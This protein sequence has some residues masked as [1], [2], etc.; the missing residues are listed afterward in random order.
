VLVERGSA[1]RVSIAVSWLHPV[2]PS[3][4]LDG[5]VLRRCWVERATAVRLVEFNDLLADGF[6]TGAESLDDYL[7]VF[8]ASS[9]LGVVATFDECVV[10]GVPARDDDCLVVSGLGRVR[11]VCIIGEES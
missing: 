6:T 7:P 5:C 3:C 9:L 11:E 2:E 1:D 10:A 4:E 8:S